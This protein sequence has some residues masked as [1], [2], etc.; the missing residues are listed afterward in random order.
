M[1][2]IKTYFSKDNKGYD[3][4]TLVKYYDRFNDKIRAIADKEKYF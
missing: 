1:N 2:F 4:Y 3:F